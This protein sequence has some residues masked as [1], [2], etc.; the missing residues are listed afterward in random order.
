MTK[1]WLDGF[2]LG[3]AGGVVKFRG[4]LVLGLVSALLVWGVVR[5]Q[6]SD[7]G[8]VAGGVRVPEI[9]DQGVMTSLLTGRE[10]RFRPR[11][12]ME[13]TDLEIFFYEPDGKTVRMN[14]TSPSCFYDSM[15][16]KA[17]SEDAIRIEGDGF[18]ITGTRYE[19][20]AAEQTM[21]ILEDVTVVLK[22]ANIGAVVPASHVTLPVTLPVTLLETPSPETETT[23]TE[24]TP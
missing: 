22:N 19:Y 9:N 13:I 23:L 21:E 12:P 14:A 4:G 24:T 1:R 17:F 15:K 16:G 8:E 20:I 11:K 6:D 7:P 3:T 5:A 10:V 2:D 18:V